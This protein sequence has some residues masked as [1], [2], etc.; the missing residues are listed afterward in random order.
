MAGDTRKAPGLRTHLLALVLVVLIPALGLGTATAWHMARNYRAASEERLT[1][2]ARALALALDREVEAHAAALVA[3]A[4]SPLLDRD[5]LAGFYAHAR[6]AAEA[7]GTPIVLVGADLRQRLHTARPL[8]S[9]LPATGVPAAVRA[10][11]DT[12]QPAV[13]D[14]LV[15]AVLGV[16]VA[17]VVVPVVREGRAEAALVALVAPARLSRLLASQG[18]SDGAFAT[19][20]DSRGVVVARSAD[21]E[22]LVGRSVPGW[23]SKA[24]ARR[25]AGVLRGRA[26]PGHDVILAFRRLANASTWTVVVAEPLAAYEASWRDPLLALGAGGTATFLAALAAAAWLG[27]RILRPVRALAAQAE[28]VAASGGEVPVAEGVPVDVAEFEGLRLSMRRA[29]EALRERETRLRAV[30]D[31]AVDAIIVIDGRGRVQSF[32]RS[33]ETIFGYAADEVVGRNVSTL[34]PEPDASRHDGYLAH[35]SETGERRIIGIGREVE[36]RRKDG[37][38]VPLDLSIAE[39]RDAGGARFFT[40]IMRDITLRKEVEARQKILMR[41]VDHRAKN[42]LAVV[43]SVVRLTPVDDPRAYARAIEAR[44]SALARAHTLLAEQGW[45]G[46]DLSALVAV[47]LAPYG[48][49]SVSFV[50][51]AVPIAHTAAQPIGMVLHEMA[52][53]AAKHGALSR[54][55]GLVTLRWWLEGGGLR[56]RWEESGGPSIAEPPTRRGFG[57]RL[58]EATVRTQLGGTVERR[59][60]PGGLVCEIAVPLARAVAAERLPDDVAPLSKHKWAATAAPRGQ[61]TALPGRPAGLQ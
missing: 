57:S 24:A 25:D 28:A 32:N 15:G 31:T 2:T 60:E 33:A 38:T 51:P 43:Q 26:L 9:P 48:A 5:D 22:A 54:P 46:T 36:G 14:L 52:T 10:A 7:I 37:S 39:W 29:E 30:V 45:A 20:V 4:A 40:G 13:S 58:I 44:V 42:A 21:P 47:E 50:G 23:F 56:L 12:G 61:G 18:L 34:M 35:Y 1:D 8:G 19:L 55:G 3:L 11:L 16:P 17:A 6:G 53:N 59:W 41:E 49:T 27:R